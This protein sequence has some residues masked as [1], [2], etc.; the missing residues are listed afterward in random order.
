MAKGISSGTVA[1]KRSCDSLYAGI[2]H[3]LV[4]ED[5]DEFFADTEVIQQIWPQWLPSASAA[6]PDMS[7]PQY[8]VGQDVRDLCQERLF[9]DLIVRVEDR[10]WDLH[11]LVMAACSPLFKDIL[12]ILPPGVVPSPCLTSLSASDHGQ[13]AWQIARLCC[14]MR[15]EL[16]VG[17]RTFANST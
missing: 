15:E 11:R 2:E 1:N 9:T 3:R 16:A 5:G 8:N 17:H 7:F 14:F 13:V 4:M 10:T 6:Q 12:Q